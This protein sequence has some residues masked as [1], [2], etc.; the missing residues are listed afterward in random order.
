MMAQT[1]LQ[2]VQ[3]WLHIAC[4]KIVFIF[5]NVLRFLSLISEK[6][7]KEKGKNYIDRSVE[8]DLSLTIILFLYASA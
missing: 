8:I 5:F 6:R 1:S 4:S 2:G 7:E 3:S